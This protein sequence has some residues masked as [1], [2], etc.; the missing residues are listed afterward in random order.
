[1]LSSWLPRLPIGDWFRTFVDFLYDYV[2]WLFSAFTDLINFMIRNI[3]GVMALFPSLVL[4]L[5]FGG[6]AYWISRRRGLALFVIIAFVFVDSIEYWDDLLYTL[7][8]VI[9][10]SLI[11]LMIGIPIGILAARNDRLNDSLIRP[12]L[13]FMQTLPAFVYL[14]PAVILFGGVGDTPGVVATII[15]AMPPAVRLTNLGIRQVP[16]E[17]LEAGKAQGSTE[18]QLLFKVQLPVALPSIMAGINQT[19]MLA[20]SMVVI[21][22]MAGSFGLGREVYRAV[23]SARIAQGFESGVAVVLLAMVLD[24]FTQALGD[25]IAER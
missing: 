11:A 6:L 25:K 23:T 22:A 19:I 8:M 10:G 15:F 17:V 20:L 9:V 2:G 5:I 14:I 24:R 18:R 1:M 16:K 21:G 4:I 13:D 12:I 7:S 3:Y